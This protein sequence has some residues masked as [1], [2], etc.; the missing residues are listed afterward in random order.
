LSA[1]SPQG[2]EVAVGSGFGENA[3]NQVD[4]ALSFSSRPFEVVKLSDPEL[5]CFS[6]EMNPSFT[7]H[8]A[9]SAD[10]DDETT[11]KS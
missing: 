1:A 10:Q 7:C 2:A 5:R 9:D 8:D 3:Q 4:E 11:D 6:H